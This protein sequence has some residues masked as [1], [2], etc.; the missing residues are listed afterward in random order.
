MRRFDLSVTQLI[1]SAFAAVTATIAASYLGVTGTVIGAAV[2]SV[3]TA[4]GSA[5]FGHSLRSTRARVRAAAT[6]SWW[7]AAA[8]ASVAMFVGVLVVITGVELVAGR[9]ISDVVRGE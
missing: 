4:V 1:A 7:R 9:P 8:L 2:A 6:R 5:V 3:V